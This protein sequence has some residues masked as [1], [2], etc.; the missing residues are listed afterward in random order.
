MIRVHPHGVCATGVAS[1]YAIDRRI[2]RLARNLIGL[3]NAGNFSF[4]KSDAGP[5]MNEFATALEIQQR[6]SAAVQNQNVATRIH[7]DTGYLNKMPRGRR[8]RCIHE[9]RRPV[10]HLFVIQ[11]RFV[12]AEARNVALLGQ[13]HGGANQGEEAPSDHRIHP[14]MRYGF[15]PAKL[16]SIS[17]IASGVK[18]CAASRVTVVLKMPRFLRMYGRTPGTRS[19]RFSISS[20]LL[21]IS[22]CSSNFFS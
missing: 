18:V 7:R 22:R 8:A 13:S 17:A 10:G 1:R 14:F 19:S 20:S 5:G 6:L 2:M 21:K 4:T 11:C 9:W 16:Y 12:G 15:N 3:G